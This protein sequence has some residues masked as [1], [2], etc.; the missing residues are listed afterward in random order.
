MSDSNST[1]E[2]KKKIGIR[3]FLGAAAVT[4]AIY[5]GIA[6][7]YNWH[8]YPNTMVGDTDVSG[9]KLAE[10]EALG[11]EPTPASLE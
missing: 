7:Y 5:V 2:E 4:A 11:A 1:K 3:L 9:M 8:F 6:V 10:A